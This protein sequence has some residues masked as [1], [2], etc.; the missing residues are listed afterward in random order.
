MTSTRLLWSRLGGRDAVTWPLFWV[1][2][3]AS[4]L[5]QFSIPPVPVPFWI[6]IVSLTCA[7]LAMF[8]PLVGIWWF[9]LRN[10]SRPHPIVVL[11][12]Y[13]TATVIRAAVLTF[14]IDSLGASTGISFRQRLAGSLL[15]T[16]LVF[17]LT[18]LIVSTSREHVRDQAHLLQV[19]ADLMAT[20]HRLTDQIDEQNEAAL[21]RVQSTL[22]HELAALESVADDQQALEALRRL[23]GEVVRPMSHELAQSVPAWRPSTQPITSTRVKW[24]NVFADLTQRGP[25]LPLGTALAITLLMTTASLVYLPDLI[26]PI[27][28]AT[29]LLTYAA[30][31]LADVV[32]DRILP[33]SNQARAVAAVVIAAVAAAAVPAGAVG[34]IIGGKPGAFLAVC[35]TGFVA[36]LALLV[37]LVR[38]TYA[39]QRRTTA[40]LAASTEELRV[41][42]VR[43]HQA[44]W[45]HQRALAL[46][47]HGAMQTAVVAAAIRLDDAVRDG[48]VEPALIDEIRIDLARQID[49]LGTGA[50]QPKGFADFLGEV[51]SVWSRVAEVDFRVG[52]GTIAAVEADPILRAIV[53]EVVSEGISN[54]VRHGHATQV[55]I[56]MAQPS[57]EVI[58]LRIASNSTGED[59][60]EL[61]GLGSRLLDDCTLQWSQ[62]PT[63]DGL[64]VA[65]EFPVGHGL[66]S[67]ST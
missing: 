16:L 8:A 25:F 4:T 54:A 56:R 39:A 66:E 35:G 42:L 37:P 26:A 59:R 36:G 28:A 3:A 41:S 20:R 32:L 19:R 45:Y 21:A 14:M 31:K 48:T 11:A 43:L 62:N 44:Q 9:V 15:S 23:A 27:V 40:E 61:R 18:T 5:S 7:Q 1:S 30:F 29:F 2:L 10:S 51:D 67:V 52:A 24:A 49:V 53:M 50:R 55:S 13:L 65:A 12:G 33:R 6:R 57:E 64:E 17:I 60:P 46:A 38:S 47:L 58:G 22:T 34:A 63:P